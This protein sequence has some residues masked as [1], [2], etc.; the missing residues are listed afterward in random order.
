M[1]SR[2]TGGFSVEIVSVAERDGGLSIGYRET[3]PGPGAV[4][5]QVLTSPYHIVAVPKHT[6]DVRFAKAI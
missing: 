2:P 6:G 3:A 1:G 5:A 4:A